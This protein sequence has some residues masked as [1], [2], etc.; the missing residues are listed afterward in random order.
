MTENTR[1]AVAALL[2]RATRTPNTVEGTAIETKKVFESFMSNGYPMKVITD[3]QKR[4]RKTEMI[5]EPEELVRQLFVAVDPPVTSSGY[6]VV[7]YTNGLTE[8]LTRVL[9]KYTIN[10]PTRKLQQDFS[11]LKDRSMRLM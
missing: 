8:P 11:P 4:Q 6:A 5:P 1:L 10:K 3:V 9:R 7:P 2:H